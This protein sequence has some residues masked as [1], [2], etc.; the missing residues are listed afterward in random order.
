MLYNNIQK[1]AKERNMTIYQVA[2]KA[3]ISKAIIYCLGTGSRKSMDLM[4]A[5][6]IA[7]ALDV[8]LDELV[9]RHQK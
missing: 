1:L 8:S 7:D 4:T 2:K 5:V 6:K 3:G 9:G